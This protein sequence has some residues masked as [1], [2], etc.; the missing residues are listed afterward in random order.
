MFINQLKNPVELEEKTYKTDI[1]TV[2][3]MEGS[4]EERD[5][6]DNR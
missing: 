4:G 1:F 5:G 2:R 3:K 6:A